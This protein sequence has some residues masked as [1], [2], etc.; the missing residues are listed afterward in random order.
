VSDGSGRSGAKFEDPST[1]FGCAPLMLVLGGVMLLLVFL[2][3]NQAL[4]VEK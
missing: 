2:A 1:D 3:R 4:D